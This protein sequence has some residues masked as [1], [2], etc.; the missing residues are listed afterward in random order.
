MNEHDMI[1]VV[2]VILAVIA[3]IFYAMTVSSKRAEKSDDKR[4]MELMKK[5][6]LMA[7]LSQILFIGLPAFAATR[8]PI[9]KGLTAI[10]L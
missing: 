7:G 4:T 8:S 2:F 6:R 1:F 10:L 9:K 5:A 3:V